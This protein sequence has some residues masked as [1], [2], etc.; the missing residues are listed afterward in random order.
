MDRLSS[1]LKPTYHSLINHTICSSRRLILGRTLWEDIAGTHVLYNVQ[2]MHAIMHKFNEVSTRFQIAHSPSLHMTPLVPAT[3]AI[4]IASFF[5]KNF[6]EYLGRGALPNITLSHCQ[7]KTATLPCS[8]IPSTICIATCHEDS[9]H[10]F[11]ADEHFL[12]HALL[13]LNPVRYA[14]CPCLNGNGKWK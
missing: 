7:V 2:Y 10:G 3:Q 14:L 5:L 13:T 11:C 6:R 12:L 4:S 8:S 1:L 9:V